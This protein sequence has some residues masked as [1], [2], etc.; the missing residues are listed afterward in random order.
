MNTFGTRL[1]LTTFGESHG[2]AMGG[3]IDG[4]PAGFCIDFSKIQ[5]ELD[6]R[7]PGQSPLTTGRRET[8]TPEFLSGISPEG[9][10]LGTPIGFIIRNKD[11][12]S[13]DYDEL[14]DI[15]RPSHADYTYIKRYGIRDHRGGGRASARETVNWVT[16]GALT[17][18]WLES[19]GVKISSILSGAGKVSFVDKLT[20]DL[21]SSSSTGGLELDG[22]K[23]ALMEQEVMNAKM[24]GDSVGGSVT[25]L[26]E[27]LRPGLGNP[28]A[29][30]F[31]A[32]L[33]MAMMSINAAKGFEYGVG[34]KGASMRGSE[35]NDSF[36]PGDP[37]NLLTSTNM[38]G[39]IQGGITNGMPVF[40]TVSFKPTPTIMKDMPTTD[41]F[42]NSV[43]MKAA[44]RHD[45]CVAI[46]AAAVVK[47]M[48]ALVVGDFYVSSFQK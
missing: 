3:V 15:Y 20:T 35:A 28:L 12:R 14:K 19:K 40:F 13:S 18:Q 26:I 44:G 16:A 17:S 36:M 11:H 23:T 34:V 41:A 6:K 29:D 43:I 27:G 45:P 33:A 22:E 5:E 32:R 38:S 37:E 7:R 25:C 42:G 4:F 10:T 47:A 31:H 24:E 48:T 2:A 9:V 21:I 46:R 39:G 8:D 30:K 1:R